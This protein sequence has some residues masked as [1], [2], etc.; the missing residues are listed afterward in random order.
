MRLQIRLLFCILLLLAFPARAEEGRAAL[1]LSIFQS[2]DHLSV[3]SPQISVRT[4][5]Y[6][7]LDIEAA[8]DADI[9]TAASVDVM[10]AASPRGYSELRHGYS[11]GATLHLGEGSDVGARYM[12]SFEPDYISHGIGIQASREFVDRRLTIGLAYRFAKDSVGRAG[13]PRS[14]WSA[15][16]GHGASLDMAWA[17]DP[18]MVGQLSYELQVQ[19]G[20]MESPYRY[21]PVYYPGLSSSIALSESV[22]D[23]RV[24]HALS[25]GLRRALGSGFFWSGHLRLYADSWG[26]L[27]HT[28]E[29][30]LQHAILSG[31]LILGLGAR[32]YGQGSASFY[33]Y[34][35]TS[36]SILPTSLPRFR[37]A[38]KMLSSL[39]SLLIGPRAEFS[40]G[41]FGPLSAL[42]FS[43]K[44]ELYDQHFLNF[45]LLSERRALLISTGAAGE[46]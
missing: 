17:F 8:A 20:Y 44:A 23:E 40:T 35:Y 31:R 15:L 5:V 16:D 29:L 10:A 26:M 22:P 33:E 38:D 30:E 27:S 36:A 2:D 46:F 7:L 12:P 39:W 34:R 18:Y 14:E 6:E 28:E 4:P 43:L 21:V 11:V 1:W 3:V 45:A 37:S 25:A 13:N 24:R 41:T 19:S 32:I 9:I 42:R